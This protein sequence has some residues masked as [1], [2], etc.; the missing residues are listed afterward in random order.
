MEDE[1]VLFLFK[2]Y[3]ATESTEED[4]LYIKSAFT[5]PASKGYVYIEA[6]KEVHVKRAIRGIRALKHWAM[7]LVPLH[8]MVQSVTLKLQTEDIKPKQ[9]VRQKRG[10]YN[11]DLAQVVATQDQNTVIYIKFIPRIDFVE[12][13]RARD[14]KLEGKV[15]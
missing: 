8:E 12:L 5:Q 7:K 6:D 13:E 4:R 15:T 14:E 3:I 1:T 2:R 10:V 9:W 11:N